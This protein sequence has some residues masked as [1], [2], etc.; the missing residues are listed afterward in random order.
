MLKPVGTG[1]FQ[2]IHWTE[3]KKKIPVWFMRQAG[4]YLPEY[5]KIKQNL[6]LEKVF[7]DKNLIFDITLQP[8]NR[9]DLDAAIVFSD[10]LIVCETLGFQL[11]F[12]PKPKIQ[13]PL[14]NQERLLSFAKKPLV[15]PGDQLSVQC[16]GLYEA[17]VKLKQTLRGEKTLIGFAAAPWTLLSYLL[18]GEPP[19]NQIFTPLRGLITSDLQVTH[20]VLEILTNTIIEHLKLQIEAGADLFQI[21]E[22][23]S[24]LLP[25][26][27]YEELAF[28][29]V[30]KI[31][32]AL[33]DHFGIFFP[34]P[35]LQAT[36]L[37]QFL[38]N[39]G[40]S[41]HWSIPLETLIN[42]PWSSK[43]VLQGNLDPASLFRPLDQ[44]EE[45]TY[46]LI[47]NAVQHKKGFIFN[48]GHGL[49]PKTP[50]DA[51]EIIIQTARKVEAQQES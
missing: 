31:F 46:H 20:E 29:Y 22:S 9:F 12:S 21:F 19:N 49:H 30:K 50:I 44:V 10:I 13:T 27:L 16:E 32:D 6:P 45:L 37:G 28:P 33:S 40:L 3:K 14:N 34:G 42:Q 18:A 43:L 7:H 1:R 15:R 2:T 36:Y 24:D 41:V 5:Q 48:L 17:L 38:P 23:H 25:H 8:L 51:L 11:E 47:Q 39:Q 4:R 26:Q 35:S